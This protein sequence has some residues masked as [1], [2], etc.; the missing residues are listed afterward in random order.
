MKA[1]LSARR[2]ATIPQV[3]DEQKAKTVWCHAILKDREFDVRYKGKKDSKKDG[4]AQNANR[5]RC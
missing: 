3:V 1:A 5:T 4:V 2:L